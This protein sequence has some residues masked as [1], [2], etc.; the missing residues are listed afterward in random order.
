MTNQDRAKVRNS[1]YCFLS[2]DPMSDAAFLGCLAVTWQIMLQ[3]REREQAREIE[4]DNARRARLALVERET[5][6]RQ[7][8]WDLEQLAKKAASSHEND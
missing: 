4:Y 5:K 3:A 7:R 8:V 2:G 6:E 1:K